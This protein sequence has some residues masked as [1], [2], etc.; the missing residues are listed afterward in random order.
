MAMAE[1]RSRRQ[2][3]LRRRFADELPVPNDVERA[4]TSPRRAAAGRHETPLRLA[5]DLD[6]VLADMESELVRQATMLFG[7][8]L[9]ASP[10]S[11]P[12]EGVAHGVPEFVH[13]KM[14][15]RQ[16]RRLWR[17]IGSIDGFWETLQEIEPARFI[18]W[19][20]WR[21]IAAGK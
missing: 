15:S 7:D 13:L 2:P 14:T 6:G 8:S 19:P 5:F 4:P 10:G 11:E 12:A 3:D 18:A 16:R 20:P 9:Q 17:H 1:V 21:P